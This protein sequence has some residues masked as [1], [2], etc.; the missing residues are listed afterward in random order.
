MASATP[1]PVPASAPRRSSPISWGRPTSDAGAPL[2]RKSSVAQAVG[3]PQSGHPQRLVGSSWFTSKSRRPCWP[4]GRLPSPSGKRT[5]T[6]VSASV[7]I[8]FSERP[9]GL[10]RIFSPFTRPLSDFACML[11][12]CGIVAYCMLYLCGIVAYCMLY[13]CGIVAYRG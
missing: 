7:P 1:A 5:S 4:G 10:R 13:L 9:P 8:R 2:L 3:A 12:L 6:T 11:Y